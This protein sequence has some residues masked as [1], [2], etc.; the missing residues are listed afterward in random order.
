MNKFASFFVIVA[1]TAY[2]LS[3][4]KGLLVPLVVAFFVWYFINAL[5][6]VFLKA[7][8]RWRKFC[9]L[10]AILCVV[11]ILYF[12]V[13]L[14]VATIPDVANAAP[15]YQENFTKLLDKGFTYFDV[16]RGPVINRALSELDVGS[17][18]GSFAQALTSL[19]GDFLLIWIYVAFLLYEQRSF[20]GKLN[21]LFKSESGQDT[22]QQIV[23]SIYTKLR[24][25]IWIKTLISI[26]TGLLSYGIMAWVGVD[27]AAFWGAII[28]FLNYIPTIG[29][30][31]GTV[32]P[33]LLCLVQ[34]DSLQPFFIVIAS[35]AAIQG[36]VGN[37]LEPKMMGESLNLSPVALIF[38]LVLWGSIWGIA[39]MFLCVPLMV[40]LVIILGEFEYTKPLAIVLSEKGEI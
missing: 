16:D 25:Y 7:L 39:G 10:V 1:L 23:S 29:S 31:L 2:T 21:A 35:V 38:S 4:G 6:D 20:K 36:V 30:I 12:P 32:F 34:F 11:L 26:L 33:A 15:V 14:V 13:Q 27:Y 5:A 40:M 17:L 24:S 18:A 22:A 19:V 8:P 37:I 3:I 9:F 28:F